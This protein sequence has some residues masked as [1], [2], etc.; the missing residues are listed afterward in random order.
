MNTHPNRTKRTGE[1]AVMVTTSHRGVFFGYASEKELAKV[2]TTK[3][4]NLRR[5]RN[6]ISWPSSNKGFI[7]LAS[8][9]PVADARVGPAADLLVLDITSVG[10][11]SEEATKA[12][13]LAPWSR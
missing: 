6:C 2:P 4:L 11:C 5:C 9:G 8:M 7:G 10:E 1:H 13:E 12:W 3:A